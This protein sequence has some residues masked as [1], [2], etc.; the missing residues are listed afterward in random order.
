LPSLDGQIKPGGFENSRNRR[1]LLASENR[2]RAKG[3][4]ISRFKVIWVVQSP[5]AKYF[6]FHLALI[7][8]YCRASR[9]D[10]RG[11]ARRHGR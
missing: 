10:R 6:A 2:L 1:V 8:G 7:G 4:F 11:V 3:N 5:R 9:L